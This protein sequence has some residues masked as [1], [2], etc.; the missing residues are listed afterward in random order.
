MPFS[1]LMFVLMTFYPLP[2]LF[3]HPWIL[4][5]KEKAS[6]KLYSRD[7]RHHLV[8]FW[9][10]TRSLFF[11]REFLFWQLQIAPMQLML[12]SC[13]LGVLIWCKI[14]S[15]TILVIQ[16]VTWIIHVKNISRICTFTIMTEF[17][18]SHKDIVKSIVQAAD[19]DSG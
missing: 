16:F 19:T 9:L 7:G 8:S 1:S 11:F 18:E 2:V 17:H 10:L 13:V 15:S 5:Q 4:Y 14:I 12:H 3:L 6:I